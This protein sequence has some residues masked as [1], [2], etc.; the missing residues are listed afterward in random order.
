MIKLK[1]KIKVISNMIKYCIIMHLNAVPQFNVATSL[2][3]THS[4]YL[5]RL[6]D[7]SFICTQFIFF[8]QFLVLFFSILF[9]LC[10]LV[11]VKPQSKLEKPKSERKLIYQYTSTLLLRILRLEF[12]RLESRSYDQFRKLWSWDSQ[13][14]VFVLSFCTC[15]QTA[16]FEYRFDENI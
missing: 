7:F 3:L 10:K 8:F 4:I 16:S 1:L 14:L 2:H 5:C 12:W 11:P 13:V 9:V 6:W 15:L